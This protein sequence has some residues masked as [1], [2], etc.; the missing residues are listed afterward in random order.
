MK[1]SFYLSFCKRLF[2]KEFAASIGVDYA[3]V[4]MNGTVALE[5]ALMA[6]NIGQGEGVRAL[7]NYFRVISRSKATRNLSFILCC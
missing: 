5:A 4:M 6:L 1:K 2:E 7:H 3:V